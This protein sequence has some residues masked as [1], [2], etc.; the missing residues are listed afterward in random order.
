MPLTPQVTIANGP[1]LIV[2]DDLFIAQ[3]LANAFRAS[4]APMTEPVTNI[5]SASRLIDSQP[6][7]LAVLDIKV[8]GDMVFPLA[9]RLLQRSIPIV[10]ASGYP[11]DVIPREFEG[12]PVIEKPYNAPEVA[13]ALMKGPAPS[14]PPWSFKNRLLSI[15]PH[16]L[17][18]ELRR[19][20]SMTPLRPGQ[21]LQRPGAPL[22]HVWFIESGLCILALR[23]CGVEVGLIGREGAVGVEA[24]VGMQAGANSAFNCSV[25]APGAAVRVAADAAREILARS[26]SGREAFL[27]FLR[28]LHA[29][30]A[31]T[32]EAAARM[33]IGARVARWLSMACE[34]VGQ[35][36]PVT[37]DMLS[38]YLGVRRA[39]VTEALHELEAAGGIECRRGRILVRDMARLQTCLRADR[40][41]KV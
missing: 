4:G 8:G 1:I 40:Y 38:I 23:N 34:R 24:C 9:S 6:V 37:H 41:G 2:E 3:E 22:Q 28:D 19:H 25:A 31:R 17:V 35:D 32:L 10:F 14:R 13:R 12:V 39:S 26:P 30:T 7:G 20:A 16:E 18:R 11:P 27:T 29:Q 5:D 15:L 21:V 36:I 33:G